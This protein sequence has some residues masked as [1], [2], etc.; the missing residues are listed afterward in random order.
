MSAAAMPGPGDERTFPPHIRARDPQ[1]DDERL[2]L[3]DTWDAAQSIAH[4]TELLDMLQA[5]GL[6]DYSKLYVKIAGQQVD[7][8]RAGDVIR[9][10]VMAGR[11]AEADVI[12]RD[13]TD[14][15]ANAIEALILSG[16]VES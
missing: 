7:L 4:N 14:A 8:F 6:L 3:A 12:A 11:H 1:R 2:R 10:R 13:I 9:L 15:L 5:E 16:A